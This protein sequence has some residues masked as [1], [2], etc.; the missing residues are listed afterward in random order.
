MV[1]VA[2]S[3][4]AVTGTRIALWRRGL[5]A[6]FSLGGI[7][8][9]CAAAWWFVRLARNHGHNLDDDHMVVTVIGTLFFGALGFVGLAFAADIP[10]QRRRVVVD[11]ACPCCG[12]KATRDFGDPVDR[13]DPVACEGCPA[14][15]RARGAEVREE[16][17]DAVDPWHVPYVV[18]H[19]RYQRGAKLDHHHRFHFHM[20]RMCAV[21]GATGALQARKIKGWYVTPGTE[22][23]T[24][25]LGEVAAFAVTEL[26]S[27]MTSTAAGRLPGGGV[28]RAA[29]M[30]ETEKL[31]H[32]QVAVCA[33]HASEDEGY[34]LS[35]SDDNLEFAS[36]RYYKEFL[37][38]NAID[39]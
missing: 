26:V 30:S 3:G 10:S 36:Y 28:H 14:Y 12:A 11:S 7:P 35:F 13:K 8:L 21:C 15:L 23:E 37:A 22:A 25:V 9:L 5:D 32:L 2:C 29:R 34:P 33:Q 19:A 31:S 27:E 4:A 16:S 24:N 20:P 18:P 39:K 38:R 17:L 6:V 1:E